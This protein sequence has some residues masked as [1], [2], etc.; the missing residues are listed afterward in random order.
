MQYTDPFPTA[1]K[2]SAELCLVWRLLEDINK[3]QYERGMR[4]NTLQ[5][6]TNQ[7]NSLI[8]ILLSIAWFKND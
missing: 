1:R 2:G 8:L 3:Q 5:H 4:G 7:Q 6:V